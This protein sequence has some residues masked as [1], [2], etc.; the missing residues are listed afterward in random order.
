MDRDR[1]ATEFF[2]TG[3]LFL[4]LVVPAPFIL[5]YGIAQWGDNGIAWVAFAALLFFL[6]TLLLFNRG[7]GGRRGLVLMIL[8]LMTAPITTRTRVL[9]KTCKTFPTTADSEGFVM[10]GG[11]CYWLTFEAIGQ[12]EVTLEQYRSANQGDMVSVTYSPYSKIIGSIQ[13]EEKTRD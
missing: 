12:F 10:G 2:K 13:I 3:C 11:T 8:D 7:N 1:L 4:L 5:W 9:A 6:A